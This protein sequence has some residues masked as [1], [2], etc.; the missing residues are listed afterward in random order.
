MIHYKPS[1]LLIALVATVLAVDTAA[2]PT[3]TFKTIQI[4]GAQDTS[5]Y[6]VNNA[7]VMVG[8]YVDSA[9]QR[10]GF[11][12]TGRTLTNIDDPKGT[13]TYCFRINKTGEI[14]GDYATAHGQ[15]QAFSYQGGTFT[16]IS[17]AGSTSSQALGINDLG[18][19]NGNFVDA[20]GVHGFILTSAGFTTQDVPG[21][22]ATLGGDINNAGLATEVWI[23]PEGSAES[24]L[25]D[26]ST[27]TTIDVPGA[28]DSSASAIDSAGDVVYSWEDASDNYHGSLRHRGMYANID[29]PNGTRT[30]VYG[31]NDHRMIV[32]TYNTS[33]GASLG[34]AAT[35]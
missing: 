29:E 12:L 35:F 15:L 18:Q 4:P 26:G 28:E 10:H 21:A 19:I 11:M 5:V 8:S 2:A 23:D 30:F 9:G 17:P 32:G 7:G 25:F 31:I 13:N 34:F 20:N 33:N 3:F 14:V 1:L 22:T 16:D 6:G 24:S 27:Y